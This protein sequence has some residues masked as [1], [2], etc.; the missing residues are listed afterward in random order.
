VTRRELS[1]LR[2]LGGFESKTLIY[3]T[4]VRRGTDGRIEPGLAESWTVSPDGKHFEFVLRRG[5]VFHDGEPV[6]AAAVAEHFK[7]WVGLREHDWLVCNHRIVGVEP[8]DEH[9]LAIRLTEPTALLPELCAINPCA[10]QAP[11]SRDRFG[12]FVRPVGTGSFAFV[13][14]E[15]LP[16][17]TA[18]MQLRRFDPAHPEPENGARIDLLLVDAKSPNPESPDTPLDAVRRGLADAVFGSHLIEIEPAAARAATRSR[19][20]RMHV[21]SGSSVRYLSFSLVGPTADAGLRRLVA[22]AIDRRRLARDAYEGFAEPATSWAAPALT[23]WPPRGTRAEGDRDLAAASVSIPDALVL[24]APP[25]DRLARAVAA[26][27]RDAGLEILHE[28]L[29]PDALRAR[30]R[31]A[32]FDIRIEETWGSPYDP[33]LSLTARFAPPLRTRETELTVRAAGTPAAVAALVQRAASTADDAQRRAVYAA[34]QA[35]LDRETWI[36]PLL[37]PNRI[38]VTRAELPGLESGSDLYRIALER[39]VAV[40][41]ESGESGESR[42]G[43]ARSDAR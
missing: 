43:T 37:V 20:L 42:D 35:E 31:D 26:Q 8:L 4:L 7:R 14:L 11:G 19:S 9:R 5:A 30:L 10:I 27:L 29:Q 15:E 6:T 23:V 33:F 1:P 21:R 38:D 17:G 41:G 2:Y 16:D 39:L 22:S 25:G 24:V 12:D 40:R 18:R 3:E 36:V 13:G 34:V 28:E 32:T